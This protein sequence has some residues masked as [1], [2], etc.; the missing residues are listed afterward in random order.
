LVAKA[1][2]ISLPGRS[3]G[4]IAPAWTGSVREIDRVFI[5]LCIDPRTGHGLEANYP[6]VGERKE[7]VR[8]VFIFVDCDGRAGYMRVYTVCHREIHVPMAYRPT[9]GCIRSADIGPAITVGPEAPAGDAEGGRDES[10]DLPFEVFKVK[11]KKSTNPKTILRAVIAS[12]EQAEVNRVFGHS[13]VAFTGDTPVVTGTLDAATHAILHVCIQ[14]SAPI[15]Y[16]FQVEQPA[17]ARYR[18]AACEFI[19]N[20]ASMEF[21]AWRYHILAVDGT[22]TNGDGLTSLTFTQAASTACSVPLQFLR[23][24]NAHASLSLDRVRIT[25]NLGASTPIQVDDVAAESSKVGVTATSDEA[26]SVLIEVCV[27]GDANRL[28]RI[29]QLP[30]GSTDRIQQVVVTF[31]AA[32]LDISTVPAEVTWLGGSA[33]VSDP[34]G[35]VACPIS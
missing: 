28:R 1:G 35:V 23:V 4:H 10:D 29:L 30:A 27:H 2:A 18:I 22:D 34:G 14:D 11:N 3:R 8:S 13:N 32:G 24:N 9:T 5:R 7:A 15:Q 12:Q 17:D 26:T 6:K 25:P 31:S 33:T 19:L 20:N 16:T 21:F